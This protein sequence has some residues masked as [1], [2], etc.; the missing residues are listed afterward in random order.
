MTMSAHAGVPGPK[1]EPSIDHARCEGKLA[2]VA[3][4]PEDVFEI[5]RLEQADFAR[6]SLLG[7]MR[8]VLHGKQTVYATGAD[9]CGTCGLCVDACPEKAITLVPSAAGGQAA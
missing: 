2:C 7:K 4:C 5:R 9:R 3:V 8:S 1:M 6:L